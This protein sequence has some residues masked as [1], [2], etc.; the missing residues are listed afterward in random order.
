MSS[1][2]GAGSLPAQRTESVMSGCSSKAKPL[3]SMGS[4]A[5]P[6]SAAS[7]KLV[8]PAASQAARSEVMT[9]ALAMASAAKAGSASASALSAA[10]P[11][12]DAEAATPIASIAPEA[13]MVS[14]SRLPAKAPSAIAVHSDT[15]A[16]LAPKPAGAAMSVSA[17]SAA[18]SASV[19][20]LYRMPFQEMRGSLSVP[21]VGNSTAES[22]V[23]REKTQAGTE[24]ADTGSTA[25]PSIPSGT[26]RR[27]VSSS[28][29]S[30]PLW[31]E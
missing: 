22:L 11:S 9:V 26:R 18:S 8:N 3:P 2:A 14:R 15:I 1:A 10:P 5:S 21:P 25:A 31:L 19:F 17:P 24:A 30:M 13:T 12:S 23:H 4:M 27:F 16:A 20:L 7:A 29:K 28:S 6:G